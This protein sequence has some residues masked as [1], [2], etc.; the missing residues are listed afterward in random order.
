MSFIKDKDK[1]NSSLWDWIIL[2]VILVGGIGFWQYISFQSNRTTNDLRKADSLF[3]A[4]KYQEARKA[5][6]NLGD[7]DYL[8]DQ[9]DSI[10]YERLEDL[11]S[12]LE[13]K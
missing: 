9:H 3:N 6:D 1:E 11:D 4:G 2:A 12:L 7:H 10:I 8:S 13:L 5:Y